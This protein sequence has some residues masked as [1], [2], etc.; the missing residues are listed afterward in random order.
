MGLKR[1]PHML[2]IASVSAQNI[3]QF[4]AAVAS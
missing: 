4:V 3:R 1:R 2:L